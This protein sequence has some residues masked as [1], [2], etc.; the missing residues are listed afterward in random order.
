MREWYAKNREKRLAYLRAWAANHR[1]KR[2][3]G[4]RRWKVNLSVEA[5]RVYREKNR[6]PEMK[7]IKRKSTNKARLLHP[8]KFVARQAARN[9]IYA[10]KLIRQ[11]CEV[12]SVSETHAHH[13][14]YSKPLDVR[15]LCRKHHAEHHR[16]YP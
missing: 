6:S 10:G 15:W 9:A 3:R 11:P 1:E 12:C 7:A 2:A 8:E 14:D 5:K 13:D 4:L 16:R